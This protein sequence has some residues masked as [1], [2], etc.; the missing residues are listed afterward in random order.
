MIFFGTRVFPNS[1]IYKLGQY[2]VGAKKIQKT[3]L[4]EY[5]KPWEGANFLD[6]G[7]GTGGR[8]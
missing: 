3:F 5:V 4:D 8:F 7:C 6:I 1:V 2:L